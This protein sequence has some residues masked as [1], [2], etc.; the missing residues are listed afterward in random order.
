LSDGQLAVIM[1]GPPQTAFN[2]AY[3][4]AH[5]QQMLAVAA[6][7]LFLRHPPSESLARGRDAAEGRRAYG[8]LPPGGGRCYDDKGDCYE[9]SQ[10]TCTTE[11]VGYKW[12]GTQG[13]GWG[14]GDGHPPR[15]A[16]PT[17]VAPPQGPA[18]PP[19]H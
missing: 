14:G 7:D 18:A 15:Q 13:C 3:V 8:K 10:S 6:G 19:G 17:P 1:D 5:R 2:R 12:D 4:V 16:A 11:H 9:C